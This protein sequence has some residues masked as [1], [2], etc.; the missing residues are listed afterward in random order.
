MR[1]GRS[2][3]LPAMSE[4]AGERSKMISLRNAQSL[5]H[6]AWATPGSASRS[7]A[8]SG[9]MPLRCVI[10]GCAPA[11]I[12][13]I[14]SPAATARPRGPWNRAPSL[15]Q[16]MRR[17]YDRQVAAPCR[18]LALAAP[19]PGLLLFGLWLARL[20]QA[21]VVGRS[22]VAET[23]H[24]DL[25]PGQRVVRERRLLL[26]VALA[27]GECVRGGGARAARD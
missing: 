11:L 10:F 23:D 12:Q 7:A 5:F 17:I 27:V 1:R 3:G 18:R 25:E 21:R 19:W 4:P 9:T 13:A 2:V 20:A 15:S 8:R 16:P 6:H 26:G 24:E 14:R 22:A